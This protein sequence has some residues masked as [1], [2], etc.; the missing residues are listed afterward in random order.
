MM[1][2]MYA[3]S[4]LYLILSTC[5]VSV[6]MKHFLIHFSTPG[7]TYKIQSSI[8]VFFT[9]WFTPSNQSVTYALY[10]IAQGYKGKAKLSAK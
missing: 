10:I 9:L 1:Y 6:I 8:S 4:A 7:L 3:V 2:N 5:N